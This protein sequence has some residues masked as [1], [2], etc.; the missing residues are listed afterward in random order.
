MAQR[1]PLEHLQKFIRAYRIQ[2][3][4]LMFL[5][6]GKRSVKVISNI[7]PFLPQ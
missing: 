4:P 5:E 6:K 2:K 7:A 1:R 3:P